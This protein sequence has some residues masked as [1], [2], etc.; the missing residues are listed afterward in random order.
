[1]SEQG[2]CFD[3]LLLAVANV[4]QSSTSLVYR[5]WLKMGKGKSGLFSF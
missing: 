3:S 2:W 1:M 4:D 5:M